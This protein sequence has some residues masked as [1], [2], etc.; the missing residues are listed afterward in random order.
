MT[1]RLDRKYNRR[2]TS[3]RSTSREFAI[4]IPTFQ[5]EQDQGNPVMRWSIVTA[6]V[7]HLVLFAIHFPSFERAPDVPVPNQR[8]FVLQQVRFQ[9]PEPQKA[10]TRP[11]RKARKVPIP[12]PT[13]DLPEPILRDLPETVETWIDEEIGELTYIPDAPP[14]LGLPGIHAID[15]EVIPPL[16]VFAPQPPYTEEARQARVQGVVI[17]R[18]IIDILGNVTNVRIL[19]G[20]PG[21]LAESAQ[22]TVASWKFEPASMN[23]DPVPVYYNFTV[24][25]TLQ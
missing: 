18:A 5:L 12:D 15:G 22:S 14:S 23:G 24:N 8:A 19:K 13:P 17:I 6:V 11:K 10:Q 25:F 16:K 21:G 7:V 9:P 2:F 4:G 20:L 3:S 1:I